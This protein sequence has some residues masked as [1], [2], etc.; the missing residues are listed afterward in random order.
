MIPKFHELSTAL[1]FDLLC[2]NEVIQVGIP[3]RFD[4]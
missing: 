4:G 1:C 2:V 3:E